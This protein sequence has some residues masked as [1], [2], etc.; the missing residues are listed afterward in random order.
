MKTLAMR[1]KNASRTNSLIRKSRARE[2]NKEEGDPSAH[3]GAMERIAT[4]AIHLFSEKG[5][6][7]TA[8]R[9]IVDAAGVTKP[10]LYYYYKNKEDLFRSIIENIFAEH[11]KRLGEACGR[12][13]RK[14]ETSFAARLEQI[15]H[16]FYDGARQTPHIVRFIQAIAFSGLYDEIINFRDIWNRQ[17][18][19]IF[20]VL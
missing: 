8:V 3:E 2:D 5:Y 18:K 10:V 13:A 4:A 9:E 12:E 1:S 14:N 6:E 7:A 20:D 19:L 16:I 11:T 17:M 15:E